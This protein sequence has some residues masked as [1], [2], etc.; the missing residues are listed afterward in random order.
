MSVLLTLTV[1]GIG[2]RLNQEEQAPVLSRA[3]LYPNTFVLYNLDADSR[4]D[5]ATLVKA[6]LEQSIEFQSSRT[7]ESVSLPYLPRAVNLA[8][9][10]C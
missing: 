5:R 7:G 4:A 8:C 10:S 3:Q 2:L 6:G 1:Q 9:S